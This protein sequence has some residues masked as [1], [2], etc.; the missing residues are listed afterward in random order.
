MVMRR[1]R[2]LFYWIFFNKNN[3]SFRELVSFLT[4]PK[5]NNVAKKY[6]SAINKTENFY[7]VTFNNL[8]EKLFWPLT[9]PIEGINQVTAET[10]DSN[11]WHF[12]Q[13]E[14]TVIAQDEVLLDIG[15][16]EGLFPLTVINKCKHIYMIEPSSTFCDMLNLTFQN[17]SDKVTVYKTAVGNEDGVVY[18]EEDSLAG[19]ITDKQSGGNEIKISKIDTLMSG[20]NKITYLKADIE[21]FELEMLKGAEQT[22]KAHKPKIAITT[23]HKENDPK[24]IIG[25]IKDFVPEY[26]F[27]VKGIHGEEPKPVMIHFWI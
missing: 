27:Y 6:I 24:E 8:T 16:A 10:F 21:G 19:Q 12:Y 2:I 20:V 7:E 26:N 5:V 15:T 13:K 1:I 17:F 14:N 18:F 25:L 3:V 11:D 22:I 23:Y 4:K 9:F